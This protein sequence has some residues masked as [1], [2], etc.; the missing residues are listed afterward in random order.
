MTS[1]AEPVAFSTFVGANNRDNLDRLVR[2][3]FAEGA[4]ILGDAGSRHP[5]DEETAVAIAKRDPGFLLVRRPY[6]RADDL[7]LPTDDLRLQY[8]V[9]LLV[10]CPCP[11]CRA[12]VGY[13]C[14]SAPGWDGFHHSRWVEGLRRVLDTRE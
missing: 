14:L 10:P 8:R 13:L 7:G 5:L 11:E 3:F 4:Q 2:A 9:A 12:A 1:Y 6:R